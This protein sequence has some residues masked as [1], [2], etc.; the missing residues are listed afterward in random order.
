MFGV[1]VVLL[2]LVALF[3]VVREWQRAPVGNADLEKFD[4][5]FAA[6]PQ[7]RT[8]FKWD[9]PK[10]GPVLVA[11]HGLTTPSYVFDAITP[12]LVAMGYRVMRYD[13]IGR[14]VSDPLSAP[15]D[16][17]FFVSHLKALLADQDVPGD[18]TLLGYSM[19]GSVITAFAAAQPERIKHLILLAP[20]GIDFNETSSARLA[21]TFPIF[22]DWWMEVVVRH[23]MTKALMGE[24]HNRI[25]VGGI[26]DKQLDALNQRGYL[27][28]VLSSM[29]GILAD[30]QQD[31]HERLGQMGIPVTAIWGEADNIIPSSGAETLSKWNLDAKQE[32]ISG[33]GHELPYTH[34]KAALTAIKIGV[35]PSA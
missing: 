2:L 35:G 33:A 6:L 11:V 4:G 10:D 32:I 21:R 12:G 31:A 15:Q 7:G 22:G 24:R 19:G 1:L 3:P 14:G 9:G 29:R 17:Q 13:H 23:T 27:R 30:R 25:E 8:Y 5:N 28:A 16:A 34:P 26:V 20:A 18:L